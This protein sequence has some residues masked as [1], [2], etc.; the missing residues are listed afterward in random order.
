[1]AD[2]PWSRKIEL[3]NT[4]NS[5]EGNIML[6]YLNFDGVLHP[7]SVVFGTGSTPLL[8]ASG[9][10][11]FESA[12]TLT[13]LTSLFPS[14]RF[15]LNTWWTYQLEFEACVKRLPQSI[16]SRTVGAVLPHNTTCASM[17]NRVAMATSEAVKSKVPVMLLDHADA[18]YPKFLLHRA[19]LVDPMRGLADPEVIDALARFIVL[20]SDSDS[21]NPVHK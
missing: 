12:G 11:L 21:S 3:R 9:H 17:P 16:G 20:A 14:L 2:A 6:L 5:P 13:P 15:V 10:R 1:L 4:L 19:F 7:N 18:R 8:E